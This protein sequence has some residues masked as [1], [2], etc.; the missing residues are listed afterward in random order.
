MALVIAGAHLFSFF[1]VS[2]IS[3]PAA[4]RR[5]DLL[6][7]GRCDA[8]PRFEVRAWRDLLRDTIPYAAAMTVGI[9]YP[10]SA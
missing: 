7:A 3:S 2:V 5:R 8:A 9:L 1:Y 6:S 10:R 4:L